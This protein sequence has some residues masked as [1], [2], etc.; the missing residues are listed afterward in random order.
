MKDIAISD[1]EDQGKQSSIY[2]LTKEDLQFSSISI[3]G[4]LV[5]H[6]ILGG[7]DDSVVT[8][9]LNNFFHPAELTKPPITKPVLWG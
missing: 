5:A 1:I 9:N 7:S 3:N 6:Q 4:S 2:R 8:Y